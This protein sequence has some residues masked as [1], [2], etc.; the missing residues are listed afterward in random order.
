MQTIYTIGHSNHESDTFLR[1]LT[2]A[3]IEVIV[4]VRSNP[5]ST[6][7][8]FANRDNLKKLLKS[9]EIKYSYMGDVLG[10][11]PSDTEDYNPKTG[12]ADYTSIREKEPFKEGIDRLMNGANT[13]RICLM[14]AEENPAYCHRSLLIAKELSRRG[15]N[16]VHIRGDERLQSD[17]DLLKERAKVPANQQTLPL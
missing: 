13:Y 16:V 12:K 3:G 7:A 8:Q 1:L 10:G 4:D 6:W 15:I 9:L 5:N 2:L 17:E 14:C 11:H